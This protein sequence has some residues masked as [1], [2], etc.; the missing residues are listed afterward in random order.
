MSRRPITMG[1][2]VEG[3]FRIAHVTFDIAP[4]EPDVGIN[5]DY[6]ENLRIDVGG[7][8]VTQRLTDEELER[9]YNEIE[10]EWL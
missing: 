1:V 9:V 6:I 7:R 2:T 4:A 8:P 3:R 10:E 5:R